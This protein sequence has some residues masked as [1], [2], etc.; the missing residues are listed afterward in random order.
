LFLWFLDLDFFLLFFLFVFRLPSALLP[1]LRT[2]LLFLSSWKRIF[3]LLFLPVDPLD[4]LLVV[5]V[6][7]SARGTTF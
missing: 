3:F 2:L 5:A 4:V 6:R 7:S 1:R